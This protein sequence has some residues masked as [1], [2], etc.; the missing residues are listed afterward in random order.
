[1]I[2]SIKKTIE[3]IKKFWYLLLFILGVI[4]GFLFRGSSKSESTTSQ[5][6]TT[7]SGIKQDAT[8][9]PSEVAV[10]IKEKEQ[11]VIDS[12]NNATS[13][14]ALIN[15]GNEVINNAKKDLK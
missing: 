8:S 4:V 15:I 5:T 1:M 2:E 6:D 3:F 7:I 14:Q 11:Q 9:K 12:V 10:K 13:D